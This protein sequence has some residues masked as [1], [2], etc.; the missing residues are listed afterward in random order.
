MAWFVPA[1]MIA[2]RHVEPHIN[3]RLSKAM[4]LDLKLRIMIVDPYR[5]NTALPAPV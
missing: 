4:L 3:F 5:T 1:L 2:N